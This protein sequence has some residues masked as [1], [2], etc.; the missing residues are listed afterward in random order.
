MINYHI[1]SKIAAVILVF[2]SSIMAAPKEIGL[3]LGIAKN[4]ETGYVLSSTTPYS[5][6]GGFTPQAFAKLLFDFDNF[7]AGG[8]VGF[9]SPHISYKEDTGTEFKVHLARPLIP[10]AMLVNKKIRLGSSHFIYGGF[11]LGIGIS[12]IR[13]SSIPSGSV[14]I[15]ND[16]IMP[17]GGVQAGYT[18]YFD[19]FGINTE[20]ALLGLPEITG[21]SAKFGYFVYG[22]SVGILYRFG[23]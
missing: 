2:S 14:T 15:N 5:Q 17:L 1:K 13:S 4:S 9:L 7:Q 12:S 16:P 18:Y 8:M 22:I 19:S 23:E 10:V 11:A 3:S 20:I 21:D 6:R